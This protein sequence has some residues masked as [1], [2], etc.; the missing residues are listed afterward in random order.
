TDENLH[1]YIELTVGGKKLTIKNLEPLISKQNIKI[2]V[3]YATLKGLSSTGSSVISSDGMI[4]T[5]QLDIEFSGA[6]SM[7]L[8]VETEDLKVDMPGAGLIKLVGYANRQRLKMS[9]AGHLN[10]LNLTTNET[11]IE[12]NG[13]GGADVHALKKLDATLNGVGSIRYKGKPA[14]LRSDVRGM[15]VI[16][17]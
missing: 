2:T 4:K 3:Y 10:A 9:G 8:E 16:K 6:G 15:G 13:L 7:N 1:D 11:W 14:E 17:P 12:L 5:D